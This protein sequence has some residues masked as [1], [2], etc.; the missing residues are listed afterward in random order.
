MLYFLHC[1]WKHCRMQIKLSIH[2]PPTPCLHVLKCYLTLGNRFDHVWGYIKWSKG[3]C[4]LTNFV[5]AKRQLVV[6]W[7]KVSNAWPLRKKLKL[8]GN[9]DNQFVC[10]VTTCLH[11]PFKSKRGCRKHVNTKHGWFFY[12][13]C[14]P[15]LSTIDKDEASVGMGKKAYTRDQPTY[16]VAAGVG[17]ELLLWL[18]TPCGGSKKVC[19]ARQSASRAMKYL[20]FCSGENAE[21]VL[22]HTFID[23]CLGS[24]PTLNAFLQEIQVVWKL[25]SSGSYSYLKSLGDLM[26]FRKA[27]GVKDD[28]L[29]SFAV[30]EVYLRRG[31]KSLSR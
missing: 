30:T 14:V 23:C 1:D 20:M 31:L 12:F 17:N 11:F 26:D 4:F 27:H 2:Y 10:P 6:N 5:M 15:V 25:K 24:T 9:T 8:E 19:D 18:C 3:L 21:E 13:D 29:R 22:T 7:E 16:S 28:V